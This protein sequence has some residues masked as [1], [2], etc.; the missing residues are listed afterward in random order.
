MKTR[1]FLLVASLFAVA[2]CAA[3][4]DDDASKPEGA[5][6]TAKQGWGGGDGDPAGKNGKH[7]D[8]TWNDATLKAYSIL[9]GSALASM[10]YI[11]FI[12]P[13]CHDEVLENAI[14]CALGTDQAAYD[15][16]S[17]NWYR[18]WWGLAP[19][20]MEQP[21]SSDERKWVTGCMIQRLNFFGIE[22][23][24]LL[25]G[26]NPKINTHTFYDTKYSFDE[27][28]A[29]GDLFTPSTVGPPK[30]YVCWDDD[31]AA[32]CDP[33]SPQSPKWWLNT[34]ICDTNPACGLEIM[35]P[36]SEVCKSDS[37]TGYPLC[38]DSYG[39]YWTETVHVQLLPQ[40]KCVLPPA[41]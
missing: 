26:A 17:K 15:P 38:K 23:P 16:F 10:P 39:S 7:V 24:I 41:P 36:C 22:V 1:S 28:T 25:E 14:E 18:G 5:L 33:T 37:N 27:S 35:G 31:L 9:A 40:D 32:L 34:R 13:D 4:V 6:G 12:D 3:I 30:V 21:L 29:W 11:D 8:C 20:W 2:G 19:K